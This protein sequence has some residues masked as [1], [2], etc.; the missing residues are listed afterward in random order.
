MLVATLAGCLSK[1]ADDPGL[2]AQDDEA[3]PPADEATNSE[4]LPPVLNLEIPLD[5]GTPANDLPDETIEDVT[6][7]E[8]AVQVSADL[9]NQRK[10]ILNVGIGVGPI[11]VDA[12]V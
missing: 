5:E 4:L 3:S 11:G 9:C 8:K 10:G 1:N 7:N 12:C 2:P 6:T